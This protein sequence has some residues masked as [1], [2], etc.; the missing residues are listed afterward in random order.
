MFFKKL[1]FVIIVLLVG[2]S[3]I[4]TG[5][6]TVYDRMKL[7]LSVEEIELFLPTETDNATT[8]PDD[9]NTETDDTINDTEQDQLQETETE[10]EVLGEHQQTFKATVS[11][12]PDRILK[13]VTYRVSNTGVISVE[14]TE[15]N[16]GETTLK[17]TGLQ[18]GNTNIIVKTKEGSKEKT[19]SISVIKRIEDM[20]LNENYS[21][22]VAEGTTESI[23]TAQAINF[24]PTTTNQKNVT[25]SLLEDAEGVT[26]SEAGLITVTEKTVENVTI[27]ATSAELE[28]LQLQFDVAIIKPILQG[29]VVLTTE[30]KM[31]ELSEWLA[32]DPSND[33]KDFNLEINHFLIANNHAEANQGAFVVQV[34]SD[35]NYNVS[36]TSGNI[37]LVDAR[38]LTADEVSY[39]DFQYATSPNV[40]KVQANNLGQVR[41][42]V[43]VEID[44]YENYY[45]E[46]TVLVEAVNLATNILMN[47]SS[48]TTRDFVV[49]N[50][51]LN[52]L[53]KEIKIDIGPISTYN[54]EIK[55]Q[56]AQEDINKITIKYS[57]GT[58]ITGEDINNTV[59]PRGM[60]IYVE[61]NEINTNEDALIRQQ[62]NTV[63][64]NFIAN[65]FYNEEVEVHSTARL[66]LTQGATDLDVVENI[67]LQKNA[68]ASVAFNI[69]PASAQNDNLTVSV[70]DSFIASYVAETNSIYTIVAKNEG[71]TIITVTTTNGITKQ[72]NVEVYVELNAS[73]VEIPSPEQNYN[74]VEMQIDAT[75]EQYE[76]LRSATV[77]VGA[78]IDLNV[79]SYPSNAS[80]ENITYASSN[81]NVVTVNDNGYLLTRSIGTSTVTVTILS[82]VRD[83]EITRK[84]V[85]TQKSFVI[86]TY[87]P[88]RDISLN[89]VQI[90]LFDENS[91]GYFNLDKSE[92]QF[93]LFIN[94][95]NATYSQDVTWET[96]S[97]YLHITDSGFVRASI[98]TQENLPNNTINATVTASVV[99]YGRYYARTAQVTIKRAVKVD[100]I[101]VNNVTDGYLYFDARNGLEQAG[102][103][104]LNVQTYPY[105]ATNPN[106][107][108][109]YLQDEND[110]NTTPVFEVS[111]SGIV[112]P[113]RAGIAKLH[114]V[115]EDSF[116]NES[117]Y[118]RYNEIVVK[119]ADGLTEETALEINNTNQ[120]LEINNSVEQLSLHYVLASNIDLTNVN[121][122]PLGIIEGTAYDFTGS[123]NGKFVYANVSRQYKIKG[124]YLNE[125]SNNLQSYLGL[126]AIN[127]GSLK[128]LS[129]QINSFTSSQINNQESSVSYYA[130]IAGMNYG[131]IQD[132]SVNIINST[133]QVG[134]QNSFVSII[135]A[136]NDGDIINPITYG[137]I[138]VQELDALSNLP[139]VFVGGITAYNDVNGNLQGEYIPA[140]KLIN[141]E[142]QLNPEYSNVLYQKE[143]MNSFANI[144]TS[145]LTNQSNATGLAVGV[146][147]GVISNLATDGV[148]VGLDNVGGL[149]GINY[150][151][152]QNS[153]SATQ[154]VGE[155]NV[156]GLIGF[157]SSKTVDANLISSQIIN[158]AVEIYDRQSSYEQAVVYVEG[159]NNVGGLIGYAE[160]L[161]VFEYNYVNSYYLRQLGDNYSGDILLNYEDQSV[162]FHVGGLIGLLQNVNTVL[163]KNYANV[164]VSTHNISMQNTPYIYGGGLF[165]AISG[166]FDLNNSY[167]K[168]VVNLPLTNSVAGGLVGN[169]VNANAA[170]IDHIYS[171]TNLQ[172]QTINSFVGSIGASSN[173]SVTNDDY[174]QWDILNS[175]VW[176]QDV[177]IND[178]LPT[179]YNNL[180][181]LLINEAPENVVVTVKDQVVNV[182]PSDNSV[183]FNHLKVTDSQAVVLLQEQDYL[184]SDLINTT[185]INARYYLSTPNTDIIEILDNG[186]IKVLKQGVATIK[187]SS[188][189][190][191]NIY[192]TF[193]LAVIKGFNNFSLSNTQDNS[194]GELTEEELLQIKLNES[195]I[196]YSKLTNP[197]YDV[198]DNSGVIYSASTADFTVN[199][200]SLN[201]TLGNVPNHILTGNTTSEGNIL[202]SVTPYIRATFLDG[203]VLINLQELQ[204]SFYVSVY[205]GATEIT[206]SLASATIGLREQLELDIH[207][208]TDKQYENIQVLGNDVEDV[209]GDNILNYVSAEFVGNQN[210]QG[211]DYIYS[212][213]IKAEPNFLEVNSGS[214]NFKSAK[215][216]LL[217]FIPGSNQELASSFNITIT[218]EDLLRIDMA[219]FPAGETQIVESKPT[220]YP[221]ELP[222]DTIAPGRPG[223]LKVNLFPE[224]ANVDYYEVQSSVSNAGEYISFQQVALTNNQDE[225]VFYSPVSPSPALIPYG[226]TL[227]LISTVDKTQT[228]INY[229]FDG[230]IYVRTLIASGVER[231]TKF[232]V[233]VTGY[234]LDEQGYPQVNLSKQIELTAEVLPGV[235]LLYNGQISGQ[236]VARGTTVPIEL[237]ISEDYEGSV[238]DP[239]ATFTT[240]GNEDY[241]FD[242]NEITITNNALIDSV[243]IMK[244]DGVY[245]L[246]VGAGVPG[247]STI[248]I[249]AQATRTINGMLETSTAEI[250]IGVVDYIIEDIYVTNANSNNLNNAMNLYVGGSEL[251]QLNFKTSMFDES[252]L[253]GTDKANLQTIFENINNDIVNKQNS[254]S[255]NLRNWYERTGSGPDY[256]DT[257]LEVNSYP[258]YSIQRFT[259]ENVEYDYE[260]QTDIYVSGKRVST[261]TKLLSAIEYYYNDQGKVQPIT[262]ANGQAVLYPQN[263]QTE[264]VS[265]VPASYNIKYQEYSFNLNIVSN[266]TEDKP[267]P[268]YNAQ[269]LINMQSGVDYILL[270]DKNTPLIL[271]D[272][273]PLNTEISSLDGNNRVISIKSFSADAD[274]GSYNFGLFGSVSSSTVLKNI[275]VDIS[276]LVNTQQVVSANEFSSVNFGFIA[277][278]NQ[279]AITNSDVI[280]T[281]SEYN[282]VELTTTTNDTNFGG[283]VGVNSNGY[284]TNSRVG[285][286]DINSNLQDVMFK[287]QGNVAGF[288]G[289]NNGIIAS[290]YSANL[291]VENTS[292]SLQNSKT[293]GFTAVNA[294]NARISH[295]F[296]EGI[297]S[298]INNNKVI[299]QGQLYSVG[300]VGGFVHE[301]SGQILDSYSNIP[302]VSQSRSAGFVYINTNTG[303]I[304]NAYSA[305]K[306]TESSTSHLPFI[307]SDSLEKL[308]YDGELINTYYFDNPNYFTE[309]FAGEYPALSVNR[310]E[311]TSSYSGFGFLTEPGYEA[312]GSWT[313]SA[314]NPR[315]II[316]SA[317]E[318]TQSERRVSFTVSDG[319]EIIEF[320]YTDAEGTDRKGTGNNPI[321]VAS[322]KQFLEAMTWEFYLNNN[323]N[324]SKIRLIKDIDFNNIVNDSEL[325]KLQNITFTGIIDG[326]G[327]SMNNVRI[328]SS[329]YTEN[330]QDSFGMLNKIGRSDNDYTTTTD[331]NQTVIKNLNVTVSEI[332]A[333]DSINIGVLSG[334]ISNS[335]IINVNITGTNITVQGRNLVGSLAGKITGNSRIINTSSNLSVSSEYRTTTE[336]EGTQELDYSY[337]NEY[338]KQENQTSY[339]G[340]IAGVVDLYSFDEDGNIIQDIDFSLENPKVRVAE[341]SG[342]VRIRGEKAGGLFGYVGEH[343]Y[344]WNALFEVSHEQN[345]NVNQ[346]IVGFDIAGGIVAEN[347]GLI[348]HARIQHNKDYQENTIDKLQPRRVIGNQNLFKEY[349]NYTGGLVGYNNTGLIENSYSRVDISNPNAQVA[350][351]LVAINYGGVINKVYA[352]GHIKA[353][354]TIGGLIGE[355]SNSSLESTSSSGY[356]VGENL[357][358]TDA[359]A[360]NN[361]QISAFNN[362]N[363]AGQWQD[364][365]E[366]DEIYEVNLNK[367][368]GAF[369][370]FKQPD[371]TVEANNTWYINEL[372]E[373]IG[374]ATASQV[375]NLNEVGNNNSEDIINVL[376][377]ESLDANTTQ[378]ETITTLNYS[379]TIAKYSSLTEDYWTLEGAVRF[380]KLMFSDL[381]NIIAVTNEADLKLMKSK[382]YATFQIANDIYLSENWEP[383]SSFEGSLIGI[384]TAGQLPTIYNL[385]INSN[386]QNVGL[387]GTAQYADF[388]NFNIVVGGNENV[389]WAGDY[390]NGITS[391]NTALNSTTSILAGNL[392]D[393]SLK[394]INMMFA[395]D[396][397]SINST[398]QFVGGISA[399]IKSVNVTNASLKSSTNN[400][401]IQANISEPELNNGGTY[402]AMYVGGAFGK[403]DIGT[404]NSIRATDINFNIKT[405]TDLYAGGLIGRSQNIDIITEINNSYT[406][407]NFN[408]LSNGRDTDGTNVFVGGVV[409][410][411][412]NRNINGVNASGAITINTNEN[413]SNIGANVVYAGGIAGSLNNANVVNLNYENSDDTSINILTNSDLV[414][415]GGAIGYAEDVYLQNTYSVANINVENV[416]GTSYVGGLI[417]DIVND[418]EN[419]QRSINLSYAKVN[420]N[421]N[422]KG[423][424]NAGGL[425]GSSNKS[426]KDAE[427][428]EVYSQGIL[429]ASTTSNIIRVGGLVGNNN[430]VIRYAFASIDVNVLNGDTQQVGNL[431]G[432]NSANI[433]DAYGYGTVYSNDNNTND[434]NASIGNNSSTSSINRVFYDEDLVGLTKRDNNNGAIGLTSQELLDKTIRFYD[435]YWAKGEDTY[436]YLKNIDA[437]NL[438]PGSKMS[439]LTINSG[440]AFSDISDTDKYYIQTSDFYYIQTSDFTYNIDINIY[441][442]IE[443]F[444][445]VYNGN[446][447]SIDFYQY[448][449]REQIGIFET[450][451]YGALI[452][453][454]T[455][456]ANLTLISGS[457]YS[458]GTIAKVNKGI[459]FK[460]NAKVTTNN[461]QETSISQSNI[462][463]LVG[464]NNL[465]I[466]QSF[467]NI[468]FNLK[469][470]NVDNSSYIGGLASLS[471]QD[472]QIDQIAVINNSFTVGNAVINKIDGASVRF[473]GLV[474]SIEDTTIKNSYTAV[475]LSLIN[476][477]VST[478]GTVGIGQN[479]VSSDKDTTYFDRLIIEPSSSSVYNDEFTPYMTSQDFK[480]DIANE[481]FENVWSINK[482]TN[483]G[484]P[485]LNHL[486]ESSTNKIINTGNGTYDQ[487]YLIN[488]V[489][490]LDWVRTQ[491][492]SAAYF[493][494]THDIDLTN[495]NNL[496]DQFTAIG[497]TVTNE[498][499]RF[500][501]VTSKSF[502][503]IYNGNNKVVSNLTQ[504]YSG[505]TSIYAGLFRYLKGGEIGSYMYGYVYNLGLEDVNISVDSSSNMQNAYLGA[506][507][508][509]ASSSSQIINSY[510]SGSISDNR[511][512]SDNADKELYIGG[513]VSYINDVTIDSSYSQV[514]I[515]ASFGSIGG[516]TGVAAGSEI[517]NSYYN[518]D[519]NITGKLSLNESGYLVGGIVSYSTYTRIHSVQ[520]SGNINVDQIRLK[521][522]GSSQYGYT[523][524][525]D[526]TQNYGTGGVV[527][528]MLGGTITYATNQINIDFQGHTNNI[529]NIIGGVVATAKDVT[530]MQALS[531]QGNVRVM[532]A[533]NESSAYIGGVIGYASSDTNRTIEYIE[534][535]EN[536]NIKSYQYSTYGTKEELV[537]AGGLIGYIPSNNNN[538]Y[539]LDNSYNAGNVNLESPLNVK[540]GGLVGYSYG[541]ITD[542]YNEGIVGATSTL[543]NNEKGEHNENVSIDVGGI[544]GHI[545]DANISK[546]Y[547]TGFIGIL[548]QDEPTGSNDYMFSA[549]G[550]AG[551]ADG[552]LNNY[553][554]K[555]HNQA[556]ILVETQYEHDITYISAGVHAGGITGITGID[557]RNSYNKGDITGKFVAEDTARLGGITGLQDQLRSI[558]KV[559]NTGKILQAG[560]GEAYRRGQ[561]SGQV[562]NLQNDNTEIKDHYFYNQQIID[563]YQGRSPYGDYIT[564]DVY[565]GSYGYNFVEGQEEYHDLHNDSEDNGKPLYLLKKQDTYDY[566]DFRQIWDIEE[567]VSTP[568][569]Q[570][571]PS[572]ININDATA[573]SPVVNL[574]NLQL[575]VGE[576][577]IPN[578]ALG[579]PGDIELE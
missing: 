33:P 559:Y 57:D 173:V 290:S 77:A 352:T 318:L 227:S 447:Y 485:Y 506:I 317:L 204:K 15:F 350:G 279:G 115:A 70:E 330:M 111:E 422:A 63:E 24:F 560:D 257:S 341:V 439:P 452:T 81:P 121:F 139:S 547:N 11:N 351:G 25:Y 249:T 512:K 578:K 270:N 17:V 214:G 534:N 54:K 293:A 380:P 219:H 484:Y 95:S 92:F 182:N 378:F 268:V 206:T 445:G 287:A 375:K 135:A 256:N 244:Q 511:N 384:E 520:T 310:T 472:P 61:A 149:A 71:N 56:V 123:L 246:D 225:G 346:E 187:V 442:Q 519:I 120:L 238:Q 167:S 176:Y 134:A 32:Q 546:T 178:G 191:T 410:E 55:L 368:M 577:A 525:S 569:L 475:A 125:T 456:D 266:S 222:S 353:N 487:P 502:I 463:G 402:E 294:Q 213:I 309:Q 321:V 449:N 316:P 170:S 337:Y 117:S 381:E 529:D 528:Y 150:N 1:T 557:I 108:Y 427:I 202:V 241:D 252:I 174:T 431:I 420:I 372:F 501:A 470:D 209:E 426:S 425:I 476:D 411:I 181:N 67:S 35:E 295:S 355:I 49:Y 408:V 171:T 228:P 299:E 531:N 29:D 154:V 40:V 27:V 429:T 489:G 403:F 155:Y 409:G 76:T 177:S 215:S 504:N 549:G 75:P 205:E 328:L 103:T 387:I 570:D 9:S 282:V 23:N 347:K 137:Q 455:V 544:A 2:T 385:N 434:V 119:V 441:S 106:V 450:I 285:R 292:S 5:C 302:V 513:L 362:I 4:L 575:D 367:Q 38:M 72:M 208:T 269:D 545:E 166:D 255:R 43:R 369:V 19:V 211:N 22:A 226:T 250:T 482:E 579:S 552:A 278:V 196:L 199:G 297:Q 68:E 229:N 386:Y 533:T 141:Q 283:L 480:L 507:A 164:V 554:L 497:N 12:V 263:N 340:G 505:T 437:P 6:K 421:I 415:V 26:V 314:N 172:A 432:K 264:G 259:D 490:R 348:N 457:T 527:G 576:K 291:T 140:N 36:V 454:V 185:P 129:I 419:I 473:G 96:S 399:K 41:L 298:P 413:I 466:E 574:T 197:N 251:L 323:I 481:K 461:A 14:E 65:T 364:Y 39:L 280:N 322:S 464:T 556:D 572:N 453:N 329:V 414:K 132:V 45:Q 407:V 307:G 201:A 79:L 60:S 468:D 390:P 332:S 361:W 517:I 301:N 20:Q 21:I 543:F 184:I 565:M 220:Y 133:I 494:Q 424:V 339:A 53:G 142:E 131:L 311:A 315:P 289:Y 194:T 440:S 474:G 231:G 248:T 491:L 296:V 306:I 401:S 30:E 356:N 169:V 168:G 109:V 366:E 7:E 392:N 186:A 389:K 254:F 382:T 80:I 393:S 262:Y 465:L 18:P 498:E 354:N 188:L 305:S 331:N 180:D 327:M 198:S 508:G 151:L 183:S 10:Q 113:V 86:E 530:Q 267:V 128:N 326:N 395:N 312:Y 58:T 417:G 338:N 325:Y 114:V 448:A 496:N 509:G 345:E 363:D 161:D 261:T 469:F 376:S 537:A 126:V 224:Y 127:R 388:S 335:V 112:T 94:P 124:L 159:V 564:I 37:D 242:G 281:N 62:E 400:F 44:G 471:Y 516:I 160:N 433:Y 59:L 383:I 216:G 207:I 320:N 477:A 515:Q 130:G 69:L 87:V 146:N 492:N 540:L 83:T 300:T 210:I 561:V 288:V 230:N 274:S 13:E 344:I 460:T 138:E 551:Y 275:K 203:E 102:Q 221:Q 145:Q 521:Y 360:L 42:T 357:N 542:S 405:V 232:K 98:P 189:L 438:S 190:N 153:Y 200:E 143:G 110:T 276:E 162:A 217:T 158:N 148:V 430:T 34:N 147:Y 523:Y 179:L 396:Q 195:I 233:T 538:S 462:G 553:I 443:N 74:V 358:I 85:E 104:Q 165:G 336:I 541:N 532:Y 568:T 486:N 163:S 122:T 371:A 193:E 428:H 499:S 91:L 562:H 397:T 451:E 334:K 548:K 52:S 406:D 136:Y 192:D 46:K 152:I 567:D 493:N 571:M 435:Y 379:E 50:N 284:I 458:G 550:I 467:A 436:P 247:G 243:N 566:W 260:G 82:K 349:S 374:E 510:A 359:F 47:D 218:P 313:I 459:I 573:D 116:S 144:N 212:Y 223:I 107:R 539:Y 8:N 404:S 526:S 423:F 31:A 236:V 101:S 563:S 265:E 377:I 88:I 90:E 418:N 373:V 3:G 479:V 398:S 412:V 503:G 333:T 253:L 522:A 483:Y 370:G 518:A 536:V 28:N 488:H 118:S 240:N 444:A 524:L 286:V 342:N 48:A 555:S 324:N 258:N 535:K 304:K 66:N 495:F 245:Y 416:K 16:N 89:S 446:G 157:A 271:E 93:E 84:I 237:I 343:T 272:W 78:G 391:T 97:N 99:E 500:S 234:R 175:T 558:S 277:G 235:S 73:A 303:L 319:E 514:N 156:G 105:S 273:V 394:N 100:S 51:Y 478:K 239:K 365:N 64:L 308:L